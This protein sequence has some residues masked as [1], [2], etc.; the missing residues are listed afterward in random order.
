MKTFQGAFLGAEQQRLMYIGMVPDDAPKGLVALFHGYG[1][2]MGRYKHV[3]SELVQHGY[4]VYGLDHRGHGRSGG[5]RASIEHFDYFVD[6][7]HML[8]QLARK[9]HP[10]LARFVL[11]HSMGGLI[12]THYALRH[13]AALD[14]LVLSGPALVIGDDVSPMM[15]RMSGLLARVTPHLPVVPLSTS[16][17][18]VLSRDPAVQEAF[19]SDPLTY[20]GQMRARLGY[21]MMQAAAAARARFAELTL[22]LLVMYGE[23]D[24][25]VNP[26]GARQ[27][28]AEARSRDKTLKGWP[29]ARH[30][31]YNEIE[32]N[33]VIVYTISWLDQHV[34]QGA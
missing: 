32:R 12:A 24:Q 3:M 14:G 20:K 33:D 16:A 2:H 25:L 5:I 7:A 8:V 18:S 6:D 10:N 29:G 1:E 31:I 4:I 13:Q 21:E 9:R 11:G 23:A 15:K 34:P 17:E 27:I 26:S 28:H 30:E 19:D 22:P